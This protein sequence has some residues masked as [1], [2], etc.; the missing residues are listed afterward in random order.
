[1]HKVERNLLLAVFLVTGLASLFAQDTSNTSVAMLNYLASETRVINTTKNNRLMLEEIYNKL[2]NNTN[3]GIVDETTQNFLQ[4]MLNDIES[5]RIS[6]LQRERLQLI[7]E[8]QRAQAITQAMPNPLYLLGLNGPGGLKNITTS[9]SSSMNLSGSLAGSLGGIIP[10]TLSTGNLSGNIAGSIAK[11]F[12]ETITKTAINPMKLIATFS[13]MTL[14]S[15]MK[16][17]NALDDANLEFLKENWELDDSESVTLH[18]LRSQAFNYM[19]YVARDNKLGIL[20]TLNEESIDNFVAYCMDE[21]LERRKQS[22]ET[23]Q[24]LYS[25]YAPYY[26]ELAKV[27]YDLELYQECIDVI[28]RYDAVKAPIFRKDFDYANVLPKAIISASYIYGFDDEYVNLVK[29]YLTELIENTNGSNWELRYFAAQTYINLAAIDN[30]Q[31]NLTRAYNILLDNITYLSKKQETILTTYCD[32]INEKLEKGIIKEQKKQREK[33]IKHLK[34]LRKK[35]L[36]PLQEAL[37][38]NYHTLSLLMSELNISQQEQQRINAILDKA[39][40]IPSFRH[41]YFNEPYVYEQDNFQ[42]KRKII[43][44]FDFVNGIILMPLFILAL[45]AVL[46][47]I[48]IGIFNCK[49][50]IR[51]ILKILTL[52]DVLMVAS[53]FLFQDHLADSVEYKSINLSLPVVFLSDNSK[54][55]ITIHGNK[56]YNIPDSPYFINRIQR[57]NKSD[58]GDF[59][60]DVAVLLEPIF[61]IERSHAYTMDITISTNNVSSTLV[62]DCPEGKTN[63]VLSSIK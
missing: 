21:N 46:I 44:V 35:E 22:L 52:F 7:L 12:A 1:M 53:I 58:I 10:G 32:P 17:Q 26:L 29:K 18:N 2:I 39:F 15:V 34:D 8:N 28:E 31:D 20:D 19:I 60:A 55:N 47:I 9:R 56:L 25:K 5:F 36:P 11:S 13:I 54:M 14:D 57:K 63:F 40:I 49:G 50:R 42:L 4:V 27:Y 3:P 43:Y 62:F 59:M 45:P 61:I 23:N 16:Y 37:V 30:N 51:V 6:T 24:I 38:A 48:T 33:T 41:N